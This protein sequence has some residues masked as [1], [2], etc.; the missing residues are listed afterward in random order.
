M[1]LG[2]DPT[3]QS[4]DCFDRDQHAE[5]GTMDAALRS[6][7]AAPIVLRTSRYMWRGDFCFLLQSLL[8]SR[9]EQR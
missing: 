4:E 7:M 6:G 9:L 8:L 2:R 1:C 5:T 3:V